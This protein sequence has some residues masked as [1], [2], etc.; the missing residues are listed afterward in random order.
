MLLAAA[1]SASVLCLQG[2][3]GQIRHHGFKD[4]SRGSAGD[5]GANLYVSHKGRIQT[6]NRWDLNLDGELDL[7]FTQDHDS[8]YN[9]DS[10]I[11]WGGPV[12]YQSLLPDGWQL[13]APFSIL[14]ALESASSRITRLPTQG[15]GRARIADLNGDGYQD[16]VFANFMHNYRTD[17]NAYVYWGASEGFT[18][19]N[20]LELPALRAGGVDVA[21]LNRDGYLDIVIANRGDELGERVGLRLHL[22]SYIYWGNV[23]GL[24]P[25]R[26]SSIPTISAEDVVIGDFNGDDNLD[27]AFANNN[28]QVQSCFVYWGDGSEDYVTQRRLVLERQDLLLEAGE[29]TAR[30]F[31]SG[32]TTLLASDLDADGVT[33]LVA[34]GTHSGVVFYGSDRGLS[35]DRAQKLPAQTCKG[36]AAADLNGDGRQDLVFANEGNRTGEPPPSDIFW[37][38]ADGFSSTNRTRLPTLAA[39]TV[40]AADLNQDGQ[41]DLLFGNNR[42]QR[43]SDATSY[44]Y[45]A[46]PE[47]F[48]KNHRSLLKGFGVWGSGVADLNDDGYQDILLVSHHS[49]RRGRLPTSIFWGN[50]QHRY[51]TASFSLIEPGG[52]MEYSIADL[53]DDGFPDLFLNHSD[54]AAIWWGSSAGYGSDRRTRLDVPRPTSSSIA[55]LNRDGYLDILMSAGPEKGGKVGRA[56]ILWGQEGRMVENP[57]TTQWELTRS[58]LESNAIA[59]LNRDGH[60]DLIFPLSYDDHSEIYW[61]GE[62]DYGPHSRT[63]I[64][65][66]GAPHV[67]AADLDRN[68]WLDLIFGSSASRRYKNADGPGLIYWGGSE[69]LQ[70]SKPTPLESFTSLDMTVADWNRD[71]NLDIAFTNYKSGTTRD[72]PAFI[73]WGDGGR[74]YGSHNRSL[75]RASSSAAIDSLDLNR[76]GWVDLIVSNHQVDFD[77]AAGTN[78]YWGTSSGFSWSDRTHLPTV[79]VHLDAMVDAGN[80]YNRKPEWDYVCPPVQVPPDGH[81]RKLSWSGETPLGTGLKFQVR[82]ASS[83]QDLKVSQ[84]MGPEGEDSFYLES[85]QDLTGVPQDHAWLQYRAIL[86]SPDGGNSPV[87]TEVILDTAK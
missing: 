34:A 8:V 9:P 11:Y 67:V 4:L 59:D 56:I 76:D 42:D 22:E 28:S 7:V 33:D 14:K 3:P 36:M 74:G 81:F 18:P 55:D 29:T 83:E 19:A 84:W 32:M 68:G 30:G 60:L 50:S 85:G 63:L 25:E 69:G 13:R 47:G 53:D 16:I 51:S 79:G 2:G 64:E 40:Q 75:L 45:W 38:G 72:L 20:R 23:Q 57:A 62:D 21:D 44:I 27:L 12:G 71:G 39:T 80:V 54:G 35:P 1:L 49:G 65:A 61:G 6:I 66:H 46:S 52:N 10:L 87:L 17:Q 15:G 31:P 5:S 24:H 48:S 82:T 37:A 77:H 43:G 86:T 58:E 78:I 70:V 26:R 41:I 73:Y